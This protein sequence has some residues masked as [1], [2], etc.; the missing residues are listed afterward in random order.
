MGYNNEQI[1]PPYIVQIKINDCY[2]FMV[3]Y[4]ITDKYLIVMD[5]GKGIIKYSKEDFNK[6]FTGYMLKLIPNGKI[7]KYDKKNGYLSFLKK[8]VKNNIKNIIVCFILT[9]IIADFICIKKLTPNFIL[10]IKLIS[11][12]T[13]IWLELV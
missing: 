9:I 3:I 8:L 11:A 10:S 2:H 12:S 5:P 7:V 6:I 1:I 13:G 4:K